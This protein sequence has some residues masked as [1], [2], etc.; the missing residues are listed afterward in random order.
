MLRGTLHPHRGTSCRKTNLG[1]NIACAF[2][3]F[4]KLDSSSIIIFGV[5]QNPFFE[6][7]ST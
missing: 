1:A 2:E 6:S 5:P 7:A 4:K 3:L